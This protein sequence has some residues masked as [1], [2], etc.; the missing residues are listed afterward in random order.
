[1]IKLEL[2]FPDLAAKYKRHEKDLMLVLAAAMQTNR[3]MMFDKDGADNGKEKWLPPK[4]RNGRP[5]QWKGY[6]RK[7][8]APQN[9]G[10]RP[11]H[12]PDGIVRVQGEKVFIGTKLLYARLVND[13]TANMPG[14]VLKA[15][16][17]KAL[18]I[19]IPPG[20]TATKDA[21]AA[22]KSGG[23]SD[24]EGKFI[25][26]KSV[27]IPA[28]KMDIVTSEDAKEW[29]DTLANYIAEMLNE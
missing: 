10:I 7:S 19:P 11:G 5:L 13:G 29:A 18:K 27:K 17:A 14:G 1:M 22:H 8:F 12:G 20:K 15:I 2:T 24:S 4:F 28:R 25:F 9:D 21:K 3:A 6:L 23:G 26:R 16:N